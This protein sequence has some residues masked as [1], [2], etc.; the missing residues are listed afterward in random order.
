LNIPED[1]VGFEIPAAIVVSS[2]LK[3]MPVR[4]RGCV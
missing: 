2:T 3:N 4:G 1:P